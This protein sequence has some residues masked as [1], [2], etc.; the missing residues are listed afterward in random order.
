MQIQVT[1]RGLQWLAAG[2]AILAAVILALAGDV[3]PFGTSLPPLS[4]HKDPSF[5][6]FILSD[7]TTLGFVR[8]ALVM[9]ALFMIA[10]IPA[11]IVGGR[12]VKG[13]GTTGLTADDA[14]TADQA[15]EEAKT[16]LDQATQELDAVKQE[17]DQAIQLL[18]QIIDAGN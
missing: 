11:L 13:F 8:L 17:R 9:L 1:Q 7:E 3:W 10:S 4:Q 2:L 15:L 14:A 5:W 12:W 16:K 18:R 6:Q